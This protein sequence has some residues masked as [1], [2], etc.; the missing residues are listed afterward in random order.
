M[1]GFGTQSTAELHPELTSL[2]GIFDRLRSTENIP[3]TYRPSAGLTVDPYYTL[4][5][6]KLRHP[7]R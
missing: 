6:K 2:A 1:L 5:T 3:T 4:Q 7:M